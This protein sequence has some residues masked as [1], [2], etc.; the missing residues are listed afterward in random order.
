MNVPKYIIIHHTGGTDANPLAPSS[1]FTFAQCDKLHKQRFD[2]ISSIGYYVGYQ[3]Y[4]DNQGTVRQAR[5]DNEEGAHTIGKNNSSI[6]ICLAGNFDIETP[7]ASQV[8][9]LRNLVQKKMAMYNIPIENVV[10]HRKFAQKSCYGKLLSD[11]WAQE[12][13][14]KKRDTYWGLI[15]LI[16]KKYGLA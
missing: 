4:I 1:T 14:D 9:A 6:G 3:Y 2:F 5:A 11:T 10:P 15:V 12:T 16:L 7:T 8:L 13:A